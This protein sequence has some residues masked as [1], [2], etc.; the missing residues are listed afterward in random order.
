MVQCHYHLKREKM[1]AVAGGEIDQRAKR[2]AEGE[3]SK[4]RAADLLNLAHG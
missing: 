3:S 1:S 2:K 4:G